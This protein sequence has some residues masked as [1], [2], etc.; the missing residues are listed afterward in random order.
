MSVRGVFAGAGSQ[1][2]GAAAYRYWRIYITAVWSGTTCII[3]EIELRGTVG[4]ADITSASTPATASAYSS[5]TY[6]PAKALDGSTTTYWYSGVAAYVP[7]WWACDL[8]SAQTVAQVAILPRSTA[9][10]NPVD[11]IIQGSNDGTNYADV[12]TV[13]GVDWT[14]L[15]TKTFNL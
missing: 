11:F 4:G 3:T 6:T 9:T 15:E 2:S 8:G 5:G 7:Q 1:P 13:T 14:V 10:G 12:K